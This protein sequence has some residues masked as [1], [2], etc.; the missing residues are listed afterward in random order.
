[1]RLLRTDH[2][3]PHAHTTSHPTHCHL[4]PRCGAAGESFHNEQTS[5][6][7]EQTSVGIYVVHM[8][9]VFCWFSTSVGVTVG[10]TSFAYETLRENSQVLRVKL[11]QAISV[12]DADHSTLAQPVLNS[13]FVQSLTVYAKA[14]VQHL[15][16]KGWLHGIGAAP[17]GSINANYML[18]IDEVR[19][20]FHKLIPVIIIG[21]S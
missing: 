13:T 12:F 5:F 19:H 14:V 20:V 17:A 2:P 11:S 3:H 18:W 8:H 7:N 10:V 9:A 15:E 21:F 1:M 6:H 4:V 16:S